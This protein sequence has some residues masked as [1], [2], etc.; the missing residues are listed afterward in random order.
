MRLS[1]LDTRALSRGSHKTSFKKR[2]GVPWANDEVIEHAYF[3]LFG[4]L[5]RNEG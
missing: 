5:G 2:E 4:D 1:A 3:D